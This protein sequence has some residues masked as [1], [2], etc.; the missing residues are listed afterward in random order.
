[1]PGCRW[2]GVPSTCAVTAITT[3]Q[4]PGLETIEFLDGIFAVTDVRLH[5]QLTTTD[6]ILSLRLTILKCQVVDKLPNWRRTDGDL[7][8]STRT[9]VTGLR[10][11]LHVRQPR[12]Y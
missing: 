7:D 2:A 4:R 5:Q 11:D 10:D 12:L 6:W 8:E 3:C 1:M 9:Y